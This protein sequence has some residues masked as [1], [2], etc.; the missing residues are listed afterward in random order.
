M[1]DDAVWA[2]HLPVP[3]QGSSSRPSHLDMT[4]HELAE[5]V[6]LLEGFSTRPVP[7]AVD[8]LVYR[9]EAAE[10]PSGIER[11]AHRLF[12]GFDRSRLRRIA[13]DAHPAVGYIDHMDGYYLNFDRDPLSADDIR[14]LY[15]IEAAINRLYRVL[16]AMGFART[17]ATSSLSEEACSVCEREMFDTVTAWVEAVGESSSVRNSWAAP[18]TVACKPGGPWDVLT[19]LAHICESLNVIVRLEYDIRFDAEGQLVR[20]RYIVP[21]ASC[22]AAEVFD[23]ESCAWVARTD[24]ELQ[25]IAEEYAARIALVLASA[26]FAAG[27][28]VEACLIEAVGEEQ[29]FVNAVRIDRPSFLAKIAPAARELDGMP[30]EVH[31]AGMLLEHYQTAERF[32]AAGASSRARYVLPREDARVLP[33]ELRQLLRADT[34][35]DLE[36]MEP[37]DDP[38]MMRLNKLRED[39]GHNVARA[40]RGCLELVDELEARCVAQEMMADGPAATQFCENHVGRIILPVLE[41]DP[42]VRFLR[43]PDALFFARYALCRIHIGAGELERAL[44]EA[45]QLVDMAATSMQAHTILLNLLARLERYEEVIEVAK[46]GLRVTVEKDSLAYFLYRMA[47]AYWVLED[48]KTAAACY[49]LVPRSG[50]VSSMAQKELHELISEEGMGEAP[51]LS[52]ALERAA[53]QGIAI[54]PNTD[55]ARQV[56]DA[57]VLL[58]DNGFSFLAGRCVHA[59]WQLLSNDELGTVNRALLP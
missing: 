35:C 17:P 6:D 58:C 24:G 51:T 4:A 47:F 21:D 31:A 46:H 43:A 57:A 49:R 40:E 22:F 11:F 15:A 54:P 5:P 19:R 10:S 32:R 53:A 9:T 23:E 29:R 42:D 36:V 48:K 20:M 30:L 2:S 52:E 59:L 25:G 45:R 26:A 39:L 14:L 55:A 33:D 56:A 44:G 27:L 16:S 41:N 34:A 50:Q 13:Q 7:D 38:D 1:A 28:S 18:G 8:A 3:A 37:A 12:A